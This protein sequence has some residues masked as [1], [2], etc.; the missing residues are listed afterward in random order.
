MSINAATVV[1]HIVHYYN[2][3]SYWWIGLTKP[4]KWDA[5]HVHL[6]LNYYYYIQYVS[7][8]QTNQTLWHWQHSGSSEWGAPLWSVSNT[9]KLADTHGS[10]ISSVLHATLLKPLAS[11]AIK[12]NMICL[13]STKPSSHPR[14]W[15]WALSLCNS[16]SQ[17]CVLVRLLFIAHPHIYLTNHTYVH[18]RSVSNT[19]CANSNFM[20]CFSPLSLQMCFDSKDNDCQ[21]GCQCTESKP[22]TT[23]NRERA[24]KHIQS[25]YTY[26][27]AQWSSLQIQLCS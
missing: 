13:S 27:C 11:I 26:S 2:K 15:H 4:V 12:R 17:S 14:H 6:P 7:V 25:T 20:V 24:H 19:V 1:E 3:Q 18:N 9:D 21:R 8:V 16:V 10:S 22:H 23:N 5:E